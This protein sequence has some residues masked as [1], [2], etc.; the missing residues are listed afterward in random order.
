MQ[1]AGKLGI[2]ATLF[3]LIAVVALLS[4]SSESGKPC[5]VVFYLINSTVA[6]GVCAVYG[7]IDMTNMNTNTQVVVVL[8]FRPLELCT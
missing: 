5:G 8:A 7:H 2:A 4:S 6:D 1:T 3:S